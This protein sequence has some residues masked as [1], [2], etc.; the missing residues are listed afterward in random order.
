M[1][2]PAAKGIRIK[3][4]T[5]S[6]L[7]RYGSLVVEG[8]IRRIATAGVVFADYPRLFADF[9]QLHP[10]TLIAASP[11]LAALSE[12]DRTKAVHEIVNAWLL[13]NA[14]MVSVAQAAQLTVNTPIKVCDSS[15]R[16]FRPPQ[17]GRSCIVQARALSLNVCGLSA[18]VRISAGGELDVKGVGVRNGVRPVHGE[19]S[20]GLLGLKNALEEYLMERFIERL[21]GHA[22]S[23]YGTL[24]SYAVLETGFDGLRST[25]EQYPAGLL[26]RRAH[27]RNVESDLPKCD[28]PDQYAIFDLEMLF[29]RYGITSARGFFG[30]RREGARLVAYLW[31]K[32]TECSPES[33]ERLA[34]ELELEIPFEAEGVNIQMDFDEQAQAFGKQIVDFGH[35]TARRT[36]SRAVVSGVCDRPFG[37]GGVITP[38]DPCFVQA[39]QRLVPE[40]RLW[41]DTGPPTVGP[42]HAFCAKLVTDLRSGKLDHAGVATRIT[43]RLNALV[44][45]WPEPTP[46]GSPRL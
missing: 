45:H 42:H 29:R 16:G 3:P 15:R 12:T 8:D 44:S 21:L 31:G 6:I 20:D 28:T 37:W 35:Y 17:Y 33:L 9:D 2:E 23:P 34:T 18:P 36:F 25:N 26:V 1:S 38:H 40:R 43:E 39:D 10:A 27:M 4:G 32:R 19:H 24:P 46:R 30:I 5:S 41:D 13:D 7:Q 22:G 11:A 14:A